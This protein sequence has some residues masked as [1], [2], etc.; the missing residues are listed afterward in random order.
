MSKTLWEWAV[1]YD[2]KVIQV[3]DLPDKD[4]LKMFHGKRA[5]S[6]QEWISYVWMKGGVSHGHGVANK[7]LILW[8]DMLAMAIRYKVEKVSAELRRSFDIK[9]LGEI[10]PVLAKRDTQAM[11][12]NLKFAIGQAMDARAQFA[13]ANQAYQEKFTISVPVQVANF[14]GQQDA[15]ITKKLRDAEIQL[16]GIM[17]TITSKADCFMAQWSKPNTT[18]QK[19]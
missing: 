13:A 7:T 4:A 10:W 14:L 9:L 8:A 12:D 16:Q 17:S 6:V 3:Y 18:I 11:V 2:A 19:L 15:G 5:N 1:N